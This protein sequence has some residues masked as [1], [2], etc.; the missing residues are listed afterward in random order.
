MPQKTEMARAK[1]QP[2]EEEGLLYAAVAVAVVVVR[3]FPPPLDS[4]S[5]S[6]FLSLSDREKEDENSQR[7]RVHIGVFQFPWWT[8]VCTRTW[9]QSGLSIIQL[10]R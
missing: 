4:L 9:Y 2:G 8:T 1:L 6:L 3:Y 7:E 5:L 10:Y